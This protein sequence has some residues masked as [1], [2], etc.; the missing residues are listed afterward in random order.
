MFSI[1]ETRNT[2]KT[3][4]LI[5]VVHA[6]NDYYLQTKM[7]ACAIMRKPVTKH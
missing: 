4:A 1:N 2:T 6:Y 7:D 5:F 3:Y